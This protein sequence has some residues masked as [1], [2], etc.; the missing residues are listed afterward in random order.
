M[1]SLFNAKA[2]Q[3]V[4]GHSVGFRKFRKKISARASETELPRVLPCPMKTGL[5]KPG[6]KDCA[7][8]SVQSNNLIIGYPHI[9]IDIYWTNIHCHHYKALTSF[10]N[11]CLG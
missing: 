2:K 7:R 10:M 1:G 8:F 4:M 3:V 5:V 11:N 9:K 6:F